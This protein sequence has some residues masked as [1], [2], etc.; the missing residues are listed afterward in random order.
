MTG[1]KS[2]SHPISIDLLFLFDNLTSFYTNHIQ[3]TAFQ[4]Y[5]IPFIH[6]LGQ[7]FNIVLSAYNVLSTVLGVGTQQKRMRVMGAHRSGFDPDSDDQKI[8]PEGDNTQAES[9][10]ESRVLTQ[11]WGLGRGE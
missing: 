1:T 6:S 2:L 10:R 8:V 7:S 5:Q 9:Y 11:F 3:M 4:G